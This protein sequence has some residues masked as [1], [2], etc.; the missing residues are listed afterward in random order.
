M[1][2]Q[3][4][5]KGAYKEFEPEVRVGEIPRDV[6]GKLDVPFLSTAVEVLGP[7]AM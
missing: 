5:R 2:I 1:H 7:L 4:N 3:E 6:L